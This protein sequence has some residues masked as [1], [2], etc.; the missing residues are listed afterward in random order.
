MFTSDPARQQDSVSMTRPSVLMEITLYL[1]ITLLSV[2]EPLPACGN[3]GTIPAVQ[4]LRPA[5]LTQLQEVT[6]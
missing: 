4:Q 1:P 5:I 2:Q 3:S 6:L